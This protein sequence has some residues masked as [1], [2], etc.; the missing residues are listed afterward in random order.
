MNVLWLLLK[1]KRKS[2]LLKLHVCHFSHHTLLRTECICCG[3]FWGQL[4]HFH[5]HANQNKRTFEKR[6]RKKIGA[7]STRLI[8]KTHC[9]HWVHPSSWQMCVYLLH[10]KRPKLDG[11]LSS[12]VD[13]VL[14]SF[15]KKNNNIGIMLTTMSRRNLISFIFGPLDWVSISIYNPSRHSLDLDYCR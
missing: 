7:N 5:K 6:R 15:A 2:F 3:Y 12:L 14:R 13:E 1:L 10:F 8:W 11:L 9:R 4:N